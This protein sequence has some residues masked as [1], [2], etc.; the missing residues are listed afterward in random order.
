MIL[1]RPL[2]RLCLLF[3]AAAFAAAPAEAQRKRKPEKCTV[4]EHDEGLLAE[5]GVSHGPFKYART[6]T[7][8]IEQ[9]FFYLPKWIETKHFRMGFDLETWKRS[10]EHTSELQSP[11]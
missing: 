10:E 11:T 5:N 6:D 3:L 8:T 7:A 2:A 4:C 1:S 9:E